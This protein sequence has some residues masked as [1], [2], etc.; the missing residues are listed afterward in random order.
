[1]AADA[2]DAADFSSSDVETYWIT[3]DETVGLVRLFDLDDIGVGAPQFDLRI[4]SQHRGRGYGTLATK[5][6]VAHLF[7]NF[8]ELHRIEANTR[9]DNTAMHRT[10][11]SAGFTHEGRLRS[12][13]WSEDGAWFDTSVYGILRTDSRR[14]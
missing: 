2:V 4:A 10:L 14:S 12:S 7:E 11:I 1:M 6:L 3:D 8:P 5:W 13:W 9:H